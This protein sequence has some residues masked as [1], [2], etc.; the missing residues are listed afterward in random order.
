MSDDVFTHAEAYV[1]CPD[2]ELV[3]VCDTSPQQLKKCGDRW[4]VTNRYSNVSEMLESEQLDIVSVCTPDATHFEILRTLL[5]SQRTLKAILCEKPFVTSDAEAE[6]VLRLAAQRDVE[7]AVV[8]LRR[9]AENIRNLKAFL[10]QGKLGTVQAINGWYTK[11]TLHN[12]SHWVDL[13]RSLFGEIEWVEAINALK[14]DGPDPTLDLLLGLA[15][16]AMASLRACSAEHFTIFEMDI[17]TTQGRIQLLD[18]GYNIVVSQVQPSPRYSG[19]SELQSIPATFGERR[20]V[21]LHAVE[22]LVA[23]LKSGKPPASN[24]HS[25]WKTLRVSLA[26]QQAAQTGE[27]VFLNLEH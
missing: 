9:Y 19:Y 27:R 7:L 12:G 10:D 25:A 20:N 23:A 17:M 1:R 18:S 21:M 6:E 26:A 3:A 22:D 16:G 4:N 14:E 13:L 24:G 8:F 5:T 15:G 11:G 2:T